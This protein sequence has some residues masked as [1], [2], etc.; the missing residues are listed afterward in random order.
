[1]SPK[2]K[3]LNSRIDGRLAA[4]A[5]LAGVALAAPAIPNADASIVWSGPVNIAIPSTTAGIYI[6]V[7]NGV[8][9]PTPSGV[10]GWDLNLWGSTS[11]SLWASNAAE[12]L[13]GVLDDFPGGSPGLV[14][15]LPV[16]TVIDGTYNYGRTDGV[17]TSGPT[18]FLLNSG[19]SC[20]GFRFRCDDGQ[21]LYG[22]MRISLSS[23][24]SGQ[25]RAILE[26]A[27]E[28][29][30][31]PIQ[32]CVVPEPSTFALLSVMGLGAVGVRTWRKRKNDTRR[33]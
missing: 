28:N 2:S 25:P 11:L 21:L 10:P 14:D 15:N 20:F 5:T 27:Y 31:A 3:N 1:M 33:S 32:A 7:Q 19:Q 9:G 4:Y 30:G 8:Y 23:T 13:D 29:A 18:A 16:T 24:Y 26:Y 22:W 6:N 12:P 17:E